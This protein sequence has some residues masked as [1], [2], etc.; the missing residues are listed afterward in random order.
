MAMVTIATR[1]PAVR[2][3]LLVLDRIVLPL[4]NLAPARLVV[5]LAALLLLIS[6]LVMEEA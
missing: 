5:G 4:V 2:N 6:G 1:R 3:V